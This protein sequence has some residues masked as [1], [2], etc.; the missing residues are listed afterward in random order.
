MKG[1]L[2]IARIGEEPVFDVKIERKKND[3]IKNNQKF[4][5]FLLKNL[6]DCGKIH[7]ELT[8]RTRREG[9]KIRIA[10]RGCTKTLKQLYNEHSIPG[11]TRKTLPVIADSEGVVWVCGIGAAQRV[12]PTPES[13][14]V[15][16]ISYE[17]VYGG[18]NTK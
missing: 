18:N 13:E 14:F 7:G 8:V 15:Y 17:T 2:K 1:I 3:L 6:L 9:D 12:R 10:G 5:N 4:N 16:K 11:N